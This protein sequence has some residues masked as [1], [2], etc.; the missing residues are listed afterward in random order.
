MTEEIVLSPRVQEFLSRLNPLTADIIAV[1]LWPGELAGEPESPFHTEVAK[2]GGGALKILVGIH[3][4]VEPGQWTFEIANR[5]MLSGPP[6]SGKA[7]SRIAATIVMLIHDWS[8]SDLDVVVASD[9]GEAVKFYAQSDD[10]WND[11][12]WIPMKWVVDSSGRSQ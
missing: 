10:G 4:A 6:L 1:A 9:S 5:F 3:E 8:Y 11:V 7:V 12:H 2:L